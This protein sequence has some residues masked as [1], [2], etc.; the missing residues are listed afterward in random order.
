MAQKPT[1][2]PGGTLMTD[3]THHRAMQAPTLE[4]GPVTLRPLEPE[5]AVGL[6]PSFNDPELIRLLG[7]P[8]PRNAKFL[9][10]LIRSAN[11]DQGAL[12][13][14]IEVDENLAG[15]TFMDQIDWGHRHAT[16]TGILVSDAEYWGKGLGRAA[17]GR[18]LKHGFDDLALHR[19]SL[20]VLEENMRAVRS[21][22]ALGFRHEG[23]RRESL[24]LDTGWED[25]IMMGLL[26]PQLNRIA[27]AEGI[28]R[29]EAFIRTRDG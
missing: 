23:H 10:G 6:E 1:D 17:F 28:E 21:Y 18:L 9:A 3:L 26:A 4:I 12:Y 2:T 7:L 25:T 20:G 19:A 24:L 16:E 29:L 5:D 22:E 13:V 11:D 14:A 27:V 8:G 15:Y